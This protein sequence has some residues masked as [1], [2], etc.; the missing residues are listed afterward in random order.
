LKED[1]PIH[2]GEAEVGVI[3]MG[4]VGTAA[5]EEMQRRYGDVVIAVDF[6]MDTVERH[7]KMG[8][9]VVYGDA[10]DSDFWERVDLAD[11]RIV[12]VMLALPGPPLLALSCIWFHSLYKGLIYS[13]IVTFWEMVHKPYLIKK[14]C[15]LSD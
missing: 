12:L 14:T 11:S 3:G 10:D 13:V 2:T 8:R 9:N 1:E 15:K 4:G 5:Y 6:S 7:R